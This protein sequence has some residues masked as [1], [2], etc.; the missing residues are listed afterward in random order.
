[1]DIWEIYSQA[2]KPYSEKNYDAALKILDEVKRL[3]PNYRKAYQL[4]A[5]IWEKIGNYPK[6]II[7]LEKFC[8]LS[9]EQGNESLISDALANLGAACRCLT[10]HDEAIKNFCA[11]A[12]LADNN[13]DACKNLSGAIFTACNMENTAAADFQVLYDRYKK[14]LA[15]ITPYPKK[16]YNHKKIRV[17]YLS[18]NFSLHPVTNWSW[19][20]ITRLD[21]NLF[22][23]YCYSAVD[24]CDVVTKFIR[25]RV[26]FWREIFDL[27][28]A[29]AAELI[30]VDEIDILIDLAGHTPDNRLRVAAYRPASVQIS[31]VGYMNSTGLECFD[32]FLSDIY[33]A[34]NSAKYFT[35]KLI[36]L[37]HSHICYEPTTQLKPAASPCFA[38]GYVTFG[39]FNQS[40]KMSDSILRTW[41]KIL[42]AVPA[43]RLLLK[44]KIFNTSDGKNFVAERL[45]YFGFD[46]SRVEM[47]GYTVDY[48]RDYAE[49]DIALDTFPYTGGVTTC[50]ALYMG[51]PVVSKYG[52][53]HGTRFGLSILKNIGL[54]EFAVDSFDDYINR[55]VALAGDW[56]LLEILHKNLRVMMKKSPLMD[57]KGYVR[58]IEKVFVNLVTN[59]P[60]VV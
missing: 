48:L 53:R 54:D 18:G 60:P 6:E 55:A 23:V 5:C 51:V 19:S 56:E 39:S 11:A 30:R 49:V 57:S 22:E 8:R 14:Y 52:D 15:D 46:L 17:G 31:G 4:E 29:Q 3:A 43:S 50:E 2:L 58:T 34:G 45:K 1:M 24:K 37:P 32:Y 59:R 21:K 26:D 38:K 47:R 28:D 42:D 41:K 9:R 33:C 12:E 20:F 35:E 13:R 27:T 40:G 25:E 44:T 7:A 16:F 36:V 10:L